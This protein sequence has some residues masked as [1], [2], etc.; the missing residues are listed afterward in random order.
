MCTE[1]RRTEEAWEAAGTEHRWESECG[2]VTLDR[3]GTGSLALYWVWI[4]SWGSEIC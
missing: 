2:D 3:Y 1:S 4:L